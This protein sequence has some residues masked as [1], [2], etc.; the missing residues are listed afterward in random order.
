MYLV[1]SVEESDRAR[2]PGVSSEPAGPTT[3]GAELSG[4]AQP[5][6]PT[7]I[8]TDLEGYDPPVRLEWGS[9]VKEQGSWE[10]ELD[11][12]RRVNHPKSWAEHIPSGPESERSESESKYDVCEVF[13]PPESVLRPRNED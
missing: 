1:R 6:F 7:G 8:P 3:A 13:S 12:E 9:I 4:P 5:M 10:D 2:G 11:E